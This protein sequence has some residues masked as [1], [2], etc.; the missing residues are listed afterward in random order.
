M[1]EFVRIDDT[2]RFG[3]TSHNPSGGALI[4]ADETPRWYSYINSSDT[5]VQQGDFTLR[6]GLTGTYRGS[7]AATLAN[8]YASGD[9]V[10]IHAS[11][12]VNGAVGREIIKTFVINDL[13]D[14]NVLRVNNSSISTRTAGL[15]D[16]NIERIQNTGVSSTAPGMLNVNLERIQNTS[17][18]SSTNGILN[19]NL[20]AINNTNAVSTVAGLLDVNIARIQNSGVSST[21]PGMLNVNLER[22]Q[23]V[24]AISTTAGTLDVNL[25]KINN[26]AASAT[27]AGILDV[28]IARIQ[29]TGVVSTIPGLLDVNIIR[30]S[31]TPVTLTTGIDTNLTH[32][33]GVPVGLS[34]YIENKVWNAPL[35]THLNNETFG[36]GLAKI[37]SDLYFANIKFVKDSNVPNDEYTVQWFKNTTLVAS[38]QVTNP[39]ISIYKTDGTNTS[40]FTNKVLNWTNVNTGTLRGNESVTLVVSGEPYLAITS[41]VLDGVNR[42]WSNLIGLDYL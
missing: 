38:G 20:T 2:V 19:V 10:E 3:V 30:V 9:Y 7:F 42:V 36:S 17:A 22:I 31:G 13:F 26:T 1:S 16:V 29:N 32:I 21:V 4:N 33:S 5:I 11:G 12:K 41:G 24:A 23:S 37:S 27:T 40:L 35:I 18:I 34:D 25:T 8:G 28:N 6:T 15:F 14:V 39:A